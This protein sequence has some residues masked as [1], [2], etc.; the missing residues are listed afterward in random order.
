MR[1]PWVGKTVFYLKSESHE[2]KY[3]DHNDHDGDHGD[4]NTGHDNSSS[5]QQHGTSRNLH[6]AGENGAVV[7]QTGRTGVLQGQMLHH[8]RS[9]VRTAPVLIPAC[10]VN[11]VKQT[12]RARVVVVVGS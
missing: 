6:V 8:A 5:S 3:D 1:R 11:C 7:V 4:N 2:D 12:P 10:S 9:L